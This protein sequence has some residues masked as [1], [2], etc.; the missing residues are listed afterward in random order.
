VTETAS[1]PTSGEHSCG[2]KELVWLRFFKWNRGENPCESK[3]EPEE[4]DGLDWDDYKLAKEIDGCLRRLKDN[5]FV[6][7]GAAIDDESFPFL[8]EQ[9]LRVL[10]RRLALCRIRAYEVL[11]GIVRTSS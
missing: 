2:K 5:P 7:Y 9:Q 4:I 8:D 3:K 6:Y 1:A 10:N 11:P